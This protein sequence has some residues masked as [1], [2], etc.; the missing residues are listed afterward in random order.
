MSAFRLTVDGTIREG[1]V[2]SVSAAD[3][4]PATV[5]GAVRNGTA[6]AGTVRVAGVD[7]GDLHGHVGHLHA[8]MTLA[9]RGALAELARRRGHEPPQAAAIERL[10]ATLGVDDDA[11]VEVASARRRVAEAGEAESRL[12]EE[13]AAA[14][15]R[16]QTLRDLDRPDE[17]AAEEL[18]DAIARLTEAETERIAAE[19]RLRRLE[20][21]AR[22]ARDDRERRLERE[23]R[24]ANRR[25]EA[26]AWLAD[27]VYDEFAAA[28]AALASM[29]GT[30]AEAGSAPG[31]YEGDPL[32]AAAAVVRVADLGAPVVVAT[33]RF[34]DADRAA[35]L[36]ES[37]VVRVS[38]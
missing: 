35:R 17:T 9:R 37:P 29:T 4:A 21:R 22:A 36:L 11:D 7:A 32:T 26:R 2:T 8:S 18:E 5:V 25:R 12:R 24:L 23:D 30:D 19:E 14:R 15:G 33:D 1:P 3:V 34:G 16:L 6:A 10:R 28:T 38:R 31:D 13:V 27:R 20:R